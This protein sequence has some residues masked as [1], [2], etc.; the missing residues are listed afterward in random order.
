MPAIT[1]SPTDHFPPNDV[2]VHEQSVCYRTR[3]FPGLYSPKGT[4]DLNYF[5]LGAPLK[6]IENIKS[7]NTSFIQEALSK[8]NADRDS[9]HFS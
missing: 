6:L 3:T 2:S 9:Y 4:R 5:L 1:V 8:I 7:K